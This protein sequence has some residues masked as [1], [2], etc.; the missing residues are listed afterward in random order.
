MTG[1]RTGGMYAGR[2]EALG[3]PALGLVFSGGR[4][5]RPRGKISVRSVDDRTKFSFLA[6]LPPGKPAGLTGK[7][8]RGDE[9]PMT[10][11][12]GNFIGGETGRNEQCPH[13]ADLR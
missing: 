4:A 2:A 10:A 6:D 3:K 12:G 8:V 5:G 11:C 1:I 9:P 7:S 13:E